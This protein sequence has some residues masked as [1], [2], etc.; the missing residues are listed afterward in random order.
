[1]IKIKNR[2]LQ[3]VAILENAFDCG[4]ELIFNGLSSVSF[5]LPLDDSKIE[6]CQAFNFVEVTDGDR[7]IGMFRIVPKLTVKDDSNKKISYIAWH[8]ISTLLDDVLFRYHQTINW[9]TRQNIEYLLSKQTVKHWV[10]GECAFTRY[11]HYAY[12]NENGLLDSLFSIPRLFNQEYE[13]KFDTSVYP[14][15]LHLVQPSQVAE[16]EIKEAHN[17]EGISME[18]PNEIINRIYP[19]GYGEGINQLGIESVNGGI[20]YIED[21]ESIEKHGLH[22]YVWVDRR[23]EIP[24]NLKAAAEVLLKEKAN[25]EPMYKV[26]AADVSY[27]TD[28]EVHKLQC[29]R[30]V[31]ITDSDLGEFYQRIM[32]EKKDDFIGSPSN[33]SLEIGRLS[34]DIAT[35]QHNLEKKVKINELYSQGTTNIDSHDYTDNCDPNHP[36]VIRFY[37]DED[38]KNVNTLKL[39]YEVEKFRSYSRATEGGGATVESTSAGGAVV[40]ST[41][42]GGGSQ[43]TSSSGGGVS[44]STQSG[45]G[46][47]QSSSGGGDH[48][49]DMF[50]TTGTVAADTSQAVAATTNSGTIYLDGNTPTMTTFRTLS[51]SGNHSHSVTVPAH[52]HDFSVPN[53]SHSVSIPS[54]S[55]EI[56]IPDHQHSITLPD[57]IHEIEHGIYTL[58]STPTSV[59][60]KIDG[61]TVPITSTQGNDIDLIPY[62]AKDGGGKVL[63]GQWHEITITPNG[64][65]R[66]NANVISRVFIQSR[67]GGTY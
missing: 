64:L 48:R 9:T 3:T 58:P 19:L 46:T 45:G 57:H 22:Q 62:L 23:F 32:V 67:M 8:V 17:Q 6:H 59:V 53:H 66:I 14:F 44:T 26:D 39:Y 65:G 60:V 30:I 41:S 18:E 27:L 50:Q 16:C 61:N 34:E 28:E 36:A 42:S 40:K 20:P 10:L 12:E 31:K 49:H 24:E 1:M 2:Q 5:S 7:Y 55:H 29:G 37:V 51:A 63:R 25:P 52:S 47:V 38:L 56:D 4:F 43:Q 54:H 33:V 21:A 11:F 13:W 15:V 35:E